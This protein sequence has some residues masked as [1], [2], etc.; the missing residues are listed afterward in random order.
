[1]VN[2]KLAWA[3]ECELWTSLSYIVRFF[4]FSPSLSG[5][6]KKG[7]KQKKEK[8]R[9]EKRRRRQEAGKKKGQRG[10]EKRE[11]IN[12]NGESIVEG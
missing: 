11:T 8:G 7:K 3:T 4:S 1:M 9:K 6:K 2:S 12:R 10:R 5:K